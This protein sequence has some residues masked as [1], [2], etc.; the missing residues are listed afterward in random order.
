MLDREVP[1]PAFVPF[2]RARKEQLEVGGKREAAAG[3]GWR[4]CVST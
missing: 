1:P 2:G 4:A 3:G